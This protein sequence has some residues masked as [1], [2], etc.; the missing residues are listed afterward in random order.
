MEDADKP[1]FL[2]CLLLDGLGISQAT[3]ANAVAIAKMPNFSRFVK[4]YPVTLLSGGDA[5]PRRRYYS[6]GCGS[7]E[8]IDGP[9]PLG[10][11]LSNE[12]RRVLKICGSEQLTSLN[13][14]FNG[15]K[16]LP[17]PGEDRLAVTTPSRGSSLKEFAKELSGLIAASLKR[18]KHDVIIASL[19]FAQEAS[20]NGDF[21]DTVRSLQQIDRLIGKIADIVLNTSGILIITA[22]YGN[23]EKTKDLAA[24]WEDREPT[25]NP[26]PFLVIGKEYEG[27]TIG[28]ADPLEGDLSVLAPA[29][30]LAD[31]SPTVLS[32]LGIAKPEGMLGKSLI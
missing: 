5:D 28:L 8:I 4:Q 19:P 30:T 7:L 25:E 29:G 24:D 21:K 18:R 6:L 14:H 23:A 12:G 22:P 15:Q 20:A 13:Y 10:E 31:F 17:Y 32:L 3:E 9:S 11:A 26:V 2:L 27:K 16:E 1:A